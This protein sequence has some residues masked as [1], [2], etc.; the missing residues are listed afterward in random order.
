MTSDDWKSRTDPVRPLLPTGHA[1]ILC[2]FNGALPANASPMLRTPAP[3]VGMAYDDSFERMYRN[4]VALNPSVH[5]GAILIGRGGGMAGY[6][7]RGW[8]YRLFSPSRT[9]STANK[10]S[11]WN[12]CLAMSMDEDVEAMVLASGDDL[13][14]L[15]NG[16]AVRL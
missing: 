10:G 8:S 4:A 12:S 6:R 11:A 5:D 1:L 16:V 14:G 3:E 15:A 13:I 7:I 9:N 2:F